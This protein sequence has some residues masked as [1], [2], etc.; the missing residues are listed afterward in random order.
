MQRMSAFEGVAVPGFFEL[1]SAL[2]QT[3]PSA[4][5]F[6]TFR[7]W[8]CDARVDNSAVMRHREGGMELAHFIGS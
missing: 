3:L 4:R 1:K 2:V 6:S 7:V 5:E 8:N